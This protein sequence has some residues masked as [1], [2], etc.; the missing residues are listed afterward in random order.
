MVG[1]HHPGGDAL[2]GTANFIYCDGHVSRKTV[3]QTLD[4]REWGSSVYSISGQNGLALN[5]GN[6]NDVYGYSHLPAKP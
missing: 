1:R 3:K 5:S 6:P 2:G 4:L